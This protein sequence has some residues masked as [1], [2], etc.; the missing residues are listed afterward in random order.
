MAGS[1][2]DDPG[3]PQLL[4]RQIEPPQRRV[5]VE[6]AQDIGQLQRA[7]EMMGE[8]KAGLALHAEHPHRQPADRAGDPVA[9][10]IER[11]AVGGA[12][13][14]DHVHLH[15]GDHGE[16]IL[17]LEIEAA[18]RLRQAGKLRRR[19]A[20]IKR[21]DIA[22]PLRQRGAP[23]LA[24]ARIVGD[25]VDGAAERIDFEHRL[26]LGARQNPHPG[27]ERAARRRARPLATGRSLTL[28]AAF[29]RRRKSPAEA[30]RGA[31][32]YAE[33][34]QSGDGGPATDARARS[35]DRAPARC[36]SADAPAC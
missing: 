34:R 22:A 7:A 12:D 17:A 30:A 36:A 26:A 29:A 35:A 16:E 24:R 15:A 8:R 33:Q 1:V 25:V 6:I 3:R 11:G 21:L 14:G 4:A 23:W 10:K 32:Q 2:A 19:R 27:I 18:H 20:G 28:P 13:I 5:L 9:V 31:A